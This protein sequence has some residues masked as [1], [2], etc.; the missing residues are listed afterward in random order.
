MKFIVTGSSGFI[1]SA[2]VESLEKD[3]HQVV[4]LVREKKACGTDTV[5]W[6]PLI[7]IPNTSE[8]EGAD[9]VFH[10]AGENLANGRWTAE[11]KL[12]IRNSRVIGTRTL[13]SALA[14][15]QSRPKVMVSASAVGIYG[16]SQDEVVKE[17]S[18]FCGDW[19][20]Q[21]C[22]DWESE[23]AAA[24]NANIRVVSMRM[25]IVLHSSGGMLKRVLLAFRLGLGGRLGRG[26][27]PMSWITLRDVVSAF[28]FASE[29]D[30]LSGPVNL[31]A[32]EK[33][34]NADFTL[35]LGKLL[36]RP[37]ILPIPPL[38]IK[39]IFGTELA[40]SILGGVFMNVD[41]LLESGFRFQDPKLELM[42]I[43]DRISN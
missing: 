43:Y 13:A 39:L 1:G 11:R 36:R 18:P 7:G 24:K 3:N 30:N 42:K 16:V 40:S 21:V 25:G 9:A 8:L 14:G 35:A 26:T 20:S 23:T 10:L 31:C 6:D 28:R 5:F 32:P 12:R 29:T 27:Q 41:K 15:L 37:T 34:T 17:N 22:I 19:L 2:L 4:K 38:A 33:S